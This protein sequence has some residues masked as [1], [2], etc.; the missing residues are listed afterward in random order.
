MKQT[1]SELLL[2]NFSNFLIKQMGLDFRKEKYKL[3][4]RGLIAAAKEFGFDN[5]SQCIQWLMSADLTKEQIETLG[6]YLTVGETFFFREPKSFQLF[7][8]LILPDVI[9]RRQDPL[10]PVRIWSAACSSG[11]E[12]YSIAITLHANPELSRDIPFSVVASDINRI[13][14]KKA[15]EGIYSEW[16]FRGMP[17]W[18][19]RKYFS[20]VEKNRFAISPEIRKMVTLQY[21][22][23]VDDSSPE[24]SAETPGMDVIFC[25]NVLMYFS[26]EVASRVVERIT[27]RLAAGG[28]LVVSPTDAFSVSDS[29]HLQSESPD[30]PV[31]RKVQEKAK[32]YGSKVKKS[33]DAAMW[34]T[35]LP[36]PAASG[37]N[38]PLGVPESAAP[39]FQPVSAPPPTAPVTS[40]PFPSPHPAPLSTAEK[41]MDLYKQGLYGEAIA[42]LT[43]LAGESRDP[44]APPPDRAFPP[45]NIYELLARCHANQGQL[46]DAEK[47]CLKAVEANRLNPACRYLMATINLEQGRSRDAVISLKQ[48]LYIDPDFLPAHFSLGNILLQNQDFSGAHRYFDNALALLSNREDNLP[49]MEMEQGLTAG[50]MKEIILVLKQKESLK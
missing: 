36:E 44:A 24:M 25:R 6:G 42:L 39:F 26:A 16:S 13:A 45:E 22:N 18:L 5:A 17:I 21:L 31:Y 35:K 32:G 28:W 10:R 20:E 9:A 48:S 23:L 12:P 33:A 3:L 29:P 15:T 37:V 27:R 46:D 7:E 14:L 38:N 19:R 40:L 34:T 47:W 11:E 2:Y 4:E 49:V 1:I 8:T 43:P 41:G 30:A 50:R